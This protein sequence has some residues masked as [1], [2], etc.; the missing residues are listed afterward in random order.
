MRFLIEFPFVFHTIVARKCIGKVQKGEGV[1]IIALGCGL[2][3]TG[4]GPFQVQGLSSFF[5]ENSMVCTHLRTNFL[6]TIFLRTS[7]LR[8][9]RYNKYNYKRVALGL[10]SVKTSRNQ[11]TIMKTEHQSKILINFCYPPCIHKWTVLQKI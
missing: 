10:A 6:R 4:L 3:T 1:R 11:V 2:R 7:H 9:C 5:T 8:T